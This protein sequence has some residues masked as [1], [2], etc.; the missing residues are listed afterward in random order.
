MR[1]GLVSFWLCLWLLY[2]LSAFAWQA[3]SEHPGLQHLSAEDGLPSSE[4]YDIIQDGEG[5]IWISTEHGVSRF[6][7]YRFNHYG[8]EEGLR[9][10]AILHLFEDH[11]GWIWMASFRNSIFLLRDGK[12][13]PFPFQTQ[14]DDFQKDRPPSIANWIH[15]DQSGRLIISIPNIGIASIDE[16]GQLV[17]VTRNAS[18]LWSMW[19]HEG[20]IRFHINLKKFK[21]ENKEARSTDIPNKICTISTNG[22]DVHP[23]QIPDRYISKIHHKHHLNSFWQQKADTIIFQSEE[24]IFLLNTA[25]SKFECELPYPHGIILSYLESQQSERVY[26]GHMSGQRGLRVYPNRKA[27]FGLKNEGKVHVLLENKTISHLLEDRQGGIWIGTNEDGVYYISQPELFF[28]T[29]RAPQLR[30]VT[31]LSLASPD[32]CFART[33]IHQ[34]FS[35]DRYMQPAMLPGWGK[36]NS[37]GVEIYYDTLQGRLYS[38]GEL[39]YWTG[40]QWQHCYR[41]DTLQWPHSGSYIHT[42]RIVPSAFSNDRMFFFGNY[43]FFSGIR[44]AQAYQ[45]GQATPIQP[46]QRLFDVLQTRSGVLFIGAMQGLY[47]YEKGSGVFH[48]QDQ[49]PAFSR[50]IQRI[51]EMKDSTLVV[52]TRDEG[53]L[54]W[55]KD[56]VLHMSE[57][58]GLSSPYVKS[59]HIDNNQIVWVG[60]NIGLNRIQFF[61]FDSVSIRTFTVADGLPSNEINA[62]TSWGDQIW[63]ATVEGVVKLPLQLDDLGPAAQPRLEQVFVNGEP[64]V[65][66][67][68]SALSWT[69]NNLRFEVAALDYSQ[70]SNIPYRFRF[71]S[72]GSWQY[73]RSPDINVP[74][75]ASGQ[76]QFEIQAQGR[77]RSWSPSLVVPF[78]IQT[79]FWATFWFWSI[80]FVLCFMLLSWW[81]RSRQTERERQLRQAQQLIAME[82]QIEDLRQQAYRAQMNPHFIFNC[83]TA[84]QSFMLQED[85][86]KLMASDYL[87]KFAQLIRQ[88]LQASR[89]KLIPLKE[90]LKMLENYIQLEQFRFE[91]SF[92]YHI[93]VDSNIDRYNTHIPPML[94][95]P[96]VENAI[97]HGF[98]D[99]DYNGYLEI[100]YSRVGNMLIVTITDNGFGIFQTQKKAMARQMKHQPAGMEI[101]RKRLSI[102][103]EDKQ[104]SG[105]EVEEIVEDGAVCGTRVSVHIPVPTSQMIST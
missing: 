46:R 16:E 70:G 8:K 82:Q 56:R 76:Y 104:V 7:G 102:Q 27:L 66:D 53:I 47:T 13:T 35:I 25:E 100:N 44:S 26:V 49:H 41:K 92:D 31:S 10:P 20:Q 22:N 15:V 5:Y 2:G 57:K 50:R 3:S 42:H 91:N 77:D 1:L 94:I 65:Q 87:S 17:E 36:E 34:I 33:K 38:M 61:D 85:N 64:M 90:D 68:L 79:P 80:V 45:I 14:L 63:V 95:Q 86:D 54:F 6:N 37:A 40:R 51:L 74:Q 11:R 69:Q 93:S 24:S 19:E 43:F 99:L 58:Q 89:S 96:Y 75:L 48:L 60:T 97:I 71:K 83:L 62:I 78:Y 4:V 103:K 9:D 105:V 101:T 55:K 59:M 52:G 84:I 73:S 21:N 88:A 32:S 29:I 12:V 28:A 18:Y 67:A 30:A 72:D 23:I 39:K 98:A 81:L